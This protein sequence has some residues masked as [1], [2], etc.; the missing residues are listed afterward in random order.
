MANKG[1]FV[2]QGAV[3]PAWRR[4]ID[5]V[6]PLRPD[7]YRYCCG[8][9]GNPWD[10]E[11]LAQ[12][13]LA[14]VFALM[15]RTNIDLEQPRAYLI[16]AATHLW[17]DR[18]R[19]VRLERSYADNLKRENIAEEPAA[20][21]ALALRDAAATLFAVLPPQERAAVLLKDVLEFSLAETATMLKTSEGAVKSALHRARATLSALPEPVDQ[22][23]NTVP[24]SLVER[25]AEAL[26]HRQIGVLRDLC[27]EEVTIDM[28]GGARFESF[29][30]G[31]S[32]F[33]F[34][35]LSIP[36]LGMGDSPHWIV[37]E[38]RGE[39]IVLGLRTK[40]GVE[41]VNEIWRLDCSEN[42]VTRVRLYC[43]TPDVL[44]QVSHELGR[45]ALKRAYRSPM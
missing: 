41:G 6:E 18:L 19:R 7:L 35:H 20:I 25:F 45:R 32:V 13:V 10:G 3:R 29:D 2:V 33:E 23:V 37:E 24:R 1:K 28:V 38:H 36:G 16:R 14:R 42:K 40:A 11:D 30:E 22:P 43:F 27:M 5:E 26:S 44:E 34:A 31:R 12:D 9:T 15:G 39:P 17:F 8:L 4:F 21:D